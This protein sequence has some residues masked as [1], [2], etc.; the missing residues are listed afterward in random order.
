MCR[1]VSQHSLSSVLDEQARALPERELAQALDAQLEGL[2]EAEQNSFHQ[3][4]ATLGQAARKAAPGVVQG[5][6][7]GAVA[8]PVG[9][10][11]GGIA[12]G[13][14]SLVRQAAPVAPSPNAPAAA[15]LRVLQDPKLMQ[16]TAALV[17]GPLGAR[18]LTVDGAATPPAAVLNLLAV[19]ASQ[20]AAQAP[21]GE[22]VDEYLRGPDGELACDA[23][24][25]VARAR[26]LQ[27]RFTR[28]SP[29]AGTRGAAASPG[30]WL[31]ESGLAERLS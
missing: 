4:L 14:S 18:Q 12:G 25:P 28:E 31:V 30:Q 29:A 20:A 15:L 10:L 9:I 11:A 22:A 1:C 2:G 19:L 27:E 16:A 6:K 23:V 3:A 26:V 21:M 5:A 13:A 8:G 17:A 24:D 7:T